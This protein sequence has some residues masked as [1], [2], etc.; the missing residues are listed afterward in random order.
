M[1]KQSYYEEKICQVSCEKFNTEDCCKN[2]YTEKNEKQ[3]LSKKTRKW[4]GDLGYEIF[5][6]K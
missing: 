4:K 1:I 3:K 6:C 2:F 5:I